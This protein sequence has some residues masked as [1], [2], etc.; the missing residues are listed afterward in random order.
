MTITGCASGGALAAERHHEAPHAGVA[1]RE[2]VLIDEVLPDRH[3]VAAAAEGQLDQLA[4]RL[5]G[6]GRRGPAGRR[7]P[8]RRA[9]RGPAASSA[10]VGGHLTGRVCRVGGHPTGRFWR[11][12][13]AARRADRDP[14]GLEIGARRLAPDARRLFDAAQ[15]PAQPPQSENLLL[16]VVPQDVGH[17]GGGPQVP[18]PRQRPGAPT[19]SLAGFQVSTTGRFWVSTEVCWLKEHFSLM[20]CRLALCI[21]PKHRRWPVISDRLR[22]V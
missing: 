21:I 2:A 4:I 18:P 9:R 7:R 11:W 22:L 20:A 14:G 13:P 3:G 15:R 8:P 19:T 1:G 6:A 16:L 5:A 12:P 10:G 17:P